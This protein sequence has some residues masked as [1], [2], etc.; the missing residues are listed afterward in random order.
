MLIKNIYFSLKEVID[1][2]TGDDNKP[3][4]C[5]TLKNIAD[6]LSIVQTKLP[7]A[8]TETNVEKLW[9][10]V[11][12]RYNAQAILKY[13]ACIWDVIPHEIYAEDVAKFMYNFIEELVRTYPFYNKLLSIYAD[14]ETKLMD[15]VKATSKNLVK[16]NDTPQNNNASGTYEGDDYLTHFT[17]TEGE[18]ASPLTTKMARLK[19]IQDS[20]KNVLSDWVDEFRRLTYEEVI[21]E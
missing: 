13:N 2:L 5:E 21:N 17:K 8:L 1:D 4:D 9:Q 20:Y 16:F 15:D 18:N 11:Y 7:F 19:E 6:S 10:S 3:F 14:A 12:A